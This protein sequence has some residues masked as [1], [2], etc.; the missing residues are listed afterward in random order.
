MIAQKNIPDDAITSSKIME[1]NNI[2]V[3]T[4][5]AQCSSK[6]RWVNRDHGSVVWTKSIELIFVQNIRM[7]LRKTLTWIVDSL[8]FKIF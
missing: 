3:W 4:A 6:R 7:A 8:F 1:V 2:E 5:V